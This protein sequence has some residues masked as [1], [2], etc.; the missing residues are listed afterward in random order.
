VSASMLKF[1]FGKSSHSGRIP[2][3]ARGP[4]ETA[5]HINARFPINAPPLSR[6]KRPVLLEPASHAHEVTFGVSFNYPKVESEFSWQARLPRDL[7]RLSHRSS[8]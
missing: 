5:L 4:R 8:T 6:T 3:F 2:L 7:R 1:A